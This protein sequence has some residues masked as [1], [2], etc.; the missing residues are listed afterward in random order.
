MSEAQTKAMAD[1]LVDRCRPNKFPPNLAKFVFEQWGYDVEF[2]YERLG[3]VD[4]T[5]LN[6]LSTM[7]SS[8]DVEAVKEDLRYA[9]IHN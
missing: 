6:R 9:Y 8:G 5:E 4:V 2:W 7:L 3:G 1:D